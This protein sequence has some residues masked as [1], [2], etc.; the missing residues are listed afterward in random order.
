[1]R[2]LAVV[3]FAARWVIMQCY[4]NMNSVME[5]DVKKRLCRILIYCILHIELPEDEES[6]DFKRIN[7]LKAEKVKG[8]MVCV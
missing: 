7:K 8:K 6:E 5:D 3:L 1:M 2:G 4:A